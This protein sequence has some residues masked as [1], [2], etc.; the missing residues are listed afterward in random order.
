M[1]TCFVIQPFDNAQY[2]QRY[3]QVY[4]PAI[5]EA[6]YRPYRVDRDPT[7]SIPIENIERGISDSTICFAE[8]SEDNPNVW[9]ELGL[10]IAH[11]KEICIVCTEQR[12]RFPFDVQ[13]RLI[14]RYRTAAPSD[15]DLLRARVVERIKGISVVLNKRASIPELIVRAQAQSDELAEFEIACMG[16]LASNLISPNKSMPFYDLKREMS[17][18]GYTDLATN[19]SVRKLERRRFVILGKEVDEREGYEYDAIS[20]LDVGWVWVEENLTKFILKGGKSR[21][22]VPF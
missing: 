13:H 6:G 7:A 15:F 17:S 11:G 19:A 10:A 12:A 9:F 16:T 1:E 22:E 4:K 8:I 3:D 21:P 2:D 18:L 20:I 14:I 5:E